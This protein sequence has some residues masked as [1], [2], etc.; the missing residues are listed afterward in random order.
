VLWNLNDL[1]EKIVIRPL[2]GLPV[3][4]DL[5]VDMNQFYDQYNKIQPFLI[6]NQPAPPKER[7]QSL[8]S[9]NT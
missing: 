6:N 8:K 1:P 7:L 3:V 2:P 4:K 5:V 9:V